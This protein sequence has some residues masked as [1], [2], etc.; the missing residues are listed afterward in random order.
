MNDLLDASLI[1]VNDLNVAGLD[2]TFADASGKVLTTHLESDIQ[3]AANSA[4]KQHLSELLTPH[5]LSDDERTWVLDELTSIVGQIPPG[6]DAEPV[7]AEIYVD[8]NGVAHYDHI[9]LHFID[10]QR[11]D[12]DLHPD[13]VITDAGA[14]GFLADDL[15]VAL[16]GPKSA[17][18]GQQLT[19]SVTMT[20]GGAAAATGVTLVDTLPANVKFVSTTGG[21][22][23][24][25]RKLTFT[26]GSLAA[27]ASANYVIAMVPTATGAMTKEVAGD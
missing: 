21:V 13:G 24:V 15:F 5:E 16:S 9:V 12:D 23:P 2:L 1:E 25:D 19:Y 14:P 7:G 3:A 8:Q 10:G 17:Y 18:L 27:G 6:E 4:L 11:G 26:V 22:T 20:N